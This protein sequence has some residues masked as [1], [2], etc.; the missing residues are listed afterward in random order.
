M[1]AMSETPPPIPPT[2][3]IPPIPQEV[4]PYAQPIEQPPTIIGVTAIFSIIVGI[5]GILANLCGMAQT[6]VLT[7]TLNATAAQNFATTG[8][9]AM[10]PGFFTGMSPVPF[11]ILTITM[12]LQLGLGIYLLTAGIFAV[13]RR[14]SA[15][16]H[17]LLYASLKL[18]VS[19][20]ESSMVAWCLYEFT[21]M[22]Q[23]ALQAA[24]G[25]PAPPIWNPGQAMGTAAG[26]MLGL[27]VLY[28]I[29]VLVIFNLPNVKQYYRMDSPAQAG[30]LPTGSQTQPDPLV[31]KDK[32]H[33]RL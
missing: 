5:L 14:L 20:V 29:I 12:L 1:S 8:P 11:V 21:Q 15:R 28:P 4:I 31:P 13:R 26:L 3:W 6:A 9:S 17:H 18:T 22:V 19:I 25:R 10:P 30:Q 24:P 7:M 32:P 2:P 23:R 16:F 27:G 33:A